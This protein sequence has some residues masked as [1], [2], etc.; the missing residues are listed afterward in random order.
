MRKWGDVWNIRFEM[1]NPHPAPFP[2]ELA[3]R[4]VKTIDGPVL[5]PFAGSGTIGIAAAQLG[6][7]YYLNDI[8]PAYQSAFAQRLNAA[9]DY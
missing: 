4:M 2:L 9:K 5:D 6:Y 8:S 1:G 3:E 7:P